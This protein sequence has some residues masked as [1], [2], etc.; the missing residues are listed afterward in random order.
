MRLGPR[1]V[2]VQLGAFNSQNLQLDG[3]FSGCRTILGLF[4]PEWLPEID[5]GPIEY[6]G[7]G[8]CNDRLRDSYNRQVDSYNPQILRDRASEFVSVVEFDP[9]IFDSI[10]MIFL[11]TRSS[12]ELHFAN[13]LT[14]QFIASGDFSCFGAQVES[15]L[16]GS[17]RSCAL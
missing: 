4:F 16:R 8:W 3:I 2:A 1:I 9:S 10:P 11:Q 7:S 13:R 12:K 17:A 14:I 15:C 5:F 6:L